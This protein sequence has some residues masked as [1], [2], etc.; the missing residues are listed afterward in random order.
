MGDERWSALLDQHD[1]IMCDAVVAR[2][3]RLVK[4]TGDG[5]LAVFDSP[6]QAL[7]AALHGRDQLIELGIHIRAGV[8]ASENR[9]SWR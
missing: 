3:G 8:H 5:V 7:R 2:D 6:E 4:S 9:E 1:R